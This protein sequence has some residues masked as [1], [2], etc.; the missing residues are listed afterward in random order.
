MY[1]IGGDWVSTSSTYP[2][3]NPY[4]METVGHA[5]DAGLKE[6]S[7]AVLAAR[8]ALESWRLKPVEERCALLGRLADLLEERAPGWSTLVQAETGST[9]SIT[10]SLQVAGGL[11]DRFRYYSRPFNLDMAELPLSQGASALGA[12]GLVA[13][14]VH[15]QQQAGLILCLN[16]FLHSW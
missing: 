7:D 16:S 10:E 15:H 5:P 11:I 14:A 9:V 2:I 12:A 1:V 6:A 13:A 3:V 8:T 4:T